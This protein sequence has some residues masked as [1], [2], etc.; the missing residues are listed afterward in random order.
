MLLAI[1]ENATS[2]ETGKRYQKVT[3]LTDDVEAWL[4]NEKVSVGKE[5]FH[6]WLFRVLS[7]HNVVSK[8]AMAS[9]ALVFC[10][11]LALLWNQ[12]NH[13]LN[14]VDAQK[15]NLILA[16]GFA[17]DGIS[18]SIQARWQLLNFFADNEELQKLLVVDAT[19]FETSFESQ[20]SLIHISEPTRPY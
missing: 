9:L 3:E 20:L 11:L 4:N 8:I 16:T 6:N 13:N 18:D 19:N 15:G 2:P 7:R 17:A 5:R 12:R 1:A 14:S 10:L